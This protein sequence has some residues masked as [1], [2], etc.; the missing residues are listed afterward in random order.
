MRNLPCF[1]CRLAMPKRSIRLRDL[2]VWLAIGA[3]LLTISGNHWRSLVSRWQRYYVEH[4]SP[5]LPPFRWYES[6]PTEYL[7]S[8]FA[9]EI[10][11][12]C[13]LGIML[14]IEGVADLAVRRGRP[15]GCGQRWGH[16]SLRPVRRRYWYALGGS[17][18][19]P[20]PS[21]PLITSLGYVVTFALVHLTLYP[22]YVPYQ[23]RFWGPGGVRTRGGYVVYPALEFFMVPNSTGI[24]LGFMLLLVKASL[25]IYFATHLLVGSLPATATSRVERYLLALAIVL[26]ATS[27]FTFHWP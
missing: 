5:D 12:L 18:L 13:A 1:A 4:L 15:A 19:T 2:M 16:T 17:K 26:V 27:C 24:S 25:G 20:W 14:L 8:V 9:L 7:W 6:I 23:P 3:M 10:A 21:L 11:F 22:S